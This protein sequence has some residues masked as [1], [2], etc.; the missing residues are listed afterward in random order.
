MFVQSQASSVQGNHSNC[1]HEMYLAS[2]KTQMDR[3]LLMFTASA[4]LCKGWL[5]FSMAHYFLKAFFF[6]TNQSILLKY[7]HAYQLS[8][9]IIGVGRC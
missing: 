8:V 7:D 4:S 9:L 1:L 5:C 6:V 3:L 2:N